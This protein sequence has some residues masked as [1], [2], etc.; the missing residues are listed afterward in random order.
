LRA[1]AVP[2]LWQYFSRLFRQANPSLPQMEAPSLWGLFT[3]K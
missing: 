1:K 2:P 3:C